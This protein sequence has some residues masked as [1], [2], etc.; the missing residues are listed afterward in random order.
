MIYRNSIKCK[1]CGD[2]IISRHHHDYRTCRCRACSVDGGSDYLKR[3]GCYW[4]TSLTTINSFEEIREGFEW[5]SY[6]KDGNG[7]LKFIKLKDMEVDHI[8]AILETK[9]LKKDLLVLFVKELRFR[10]D[11]FS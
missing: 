1:N 4:E 9:D 8:L 2:E 10:N 5:G 11:K 3:S 7:E 6:G